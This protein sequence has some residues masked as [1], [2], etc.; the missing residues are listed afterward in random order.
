MLFL[1]RAYPKPHEY[2]T[3]HKFEID[4]NFYPIEEIDSITSSF[5]AFGYIDDGIWIQNYNVTL[6][7][8]DGR[9]TFNPAN[10]E[11]I[12]WIRKETVMTVVPETVD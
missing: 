4:N 3:T 2:N 10:P 12:G 6:E 5:N 7:T 8:K 1:F 9:R 11:K